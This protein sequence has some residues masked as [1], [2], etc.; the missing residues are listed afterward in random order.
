[1]PMTGLDQRVTTVADEV[2]RAVHAGDPAEARRLACDHAD[3][4]PE[5]VAELAGRCPPPPVGDVYAARRRRVEEVRAMQQAGVPPRA[6][7]ARMARH[8]T[9]GDR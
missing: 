1:M 9:G 5:L 8:H 6:I 4:T 2:T 7:A 3:I